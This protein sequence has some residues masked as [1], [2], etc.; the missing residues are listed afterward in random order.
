[1][2]L[3]WL[4]IAALP[5]VCVPLSRAQEA[6]SNTQEKQPAQHEDAR[7]QP[8]KNRLARVEPGT[9]EAERETF[10]RT[11]WRSKLV[12]ADLEQ[13]ERD[14]ERLLDLARRDRAVRDALETWSRETGEP[15]LAWTSRLALRELERAPRRLSAAPFGGS[16]EWLDLQSRFGDLQQQ[17]GDVDSMFSELQAELDTLFRNGPGFA[18]GTPGTP[19]FQGHGRSQ[20]ESFSLEVGPDGVVA[21]VTEDVDGEKKTREYKAGTLEE[22][23]EANPELRDRIQVGAHGPRAFGG[24]GFFT[25]QRQGRLFGGDAGTLPT[26]KLGVEVTTPSAERVEN[27]G[28]EM[29]LGLHVDRT[30]PGTIAEVLGIRRGDV[31]VEINGIAINGREDIAAALRERRPD[32]PVSVVLFDGKD[33]RRT[34]TWNPADSDGKSSDGSPEPKAD[35]EARKF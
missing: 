31:L 1:M 22:L 18:P 35:G 15:D 12:H 9:E 14:F 5:L 6:Q 8:R 32:Q 19:G 13:R 3:S 20:S 2:K 30:V 34:L 11:A 4:S 21:K 27:L 28:I 29:G 16:P 26:D 25:P 10:D 7:I 24:H 33:Q 17:F 23:L